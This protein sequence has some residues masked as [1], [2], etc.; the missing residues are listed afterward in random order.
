MLHSTGAS[1]TIHCGAT[2]RDAGAAAAATAPQPLLWLAVGWRCALIWLAPAAL[3]AVPPL[4]QLPGTAAC[5]SD[6]GTAGT[7]DDGRALDFPA[8]VVVSPDGRNVYVASLVSDAIVAFDRDA[9]TGT[10]A[11]QGIPDGCVS[12]DG[13][14]GDCTDGVAL[15]GAIGAAVSP[16]GGNVYVASQFAGAVAV[17]DRD[18]ITGALTQK[19]STA[20]CISDDG[21]GG[22]CVDGAALD[23]AFSIAVSPDGRNVY[24]AAAVSDAVAIFDRDLATGALTQKAGA[25]GCINLTGAGGCTMG[26]A[27]D[28]PVSVAV[29]P[30]GRS[31]YVAALTSDAIVVLDRDLATGALTQQPLFCVAETDVG[32]QCMVGKA[33]DGAAGVAVSADG[34]SVYVASQV[35]SAVAVFD[36]NPATSALQQKAGTLGCISETGTG[37]M[38]ADGSGLDGAFHVAASADRRSVYV[39]SPAGDAVAAFDRDLATG[40]LEQKA[41]RAGCVSET[42]SAGVCD[43]GVALDHPLSVAV[44]P[45]GIAVYVASRVSDAVAAFDRNQRGLDIDGDGDILALTD[46]LLLVRFAFGLTGSPLVSGAV[47]LDCTRCTAPEIEAFLQELSEP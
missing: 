3:H 12:D 47:D 41:G 9:N 2:A 11:Q 45:D 19:A 26:A 44:S 34:T 32:G 4:E 40:E 6:T 16:D 22:L 25:A 29:S 7:C 1:R 36:R 14:N 18:V 21:T 13:S 31:V 8:T 39:A 5:I 15:Q 10:L 28:E 42:G 24:V 20:G 35:S 38:C 17:F 43:D 30:D 37:G 23:D 27:L 33:L 46:G